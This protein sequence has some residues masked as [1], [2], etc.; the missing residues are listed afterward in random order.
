MFPAGSTSQ[1]V[2]VTLTDDDIPEPTK[3]YQ[4]FIKAI[5]VTGEEPIPPVILGDIT[6]AN[7]IILDN[8]AYG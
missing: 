8:D 5:S 2:K 3:Q 6:V 1:I 7:G 4:V